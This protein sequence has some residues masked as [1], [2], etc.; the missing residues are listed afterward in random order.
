MGQKFTCIRK[1]KE[2]EEIDYCEFEKQHRARIQEYYRYLARNTK[3]NDWRNNVHN[4]DSIFIMGAGGQEM[5]YNVER[6]C[7]S[8][9]R[10]IPLAQMPNEFSLAGYRFI[11]K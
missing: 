4:Y 9:N 8:I 2:P 6:Q 1:N 3:P 5:F 7:R 10:L 11:R